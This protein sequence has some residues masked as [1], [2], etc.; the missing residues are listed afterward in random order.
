MVCL[1]LFVCACLFVC[2][3]LFVIVLQDSSKTDIIQIE[4]VR[5]CYKS[6]LTGLSVSSTDTHE[7]GR[8]ERERG[9]WIR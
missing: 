7:E 6:C 9:V 1:F 4:K 2:V 5:D 3:H 8:M